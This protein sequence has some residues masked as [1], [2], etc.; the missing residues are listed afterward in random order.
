MRGLIKR[1]PPLLL[2]A[3]LMG[4]TWIAAY[5]LPTWT[6]NLPGNAAIGLVLS[7][8]GTLILLLSVWEF[9]QAQTTVNP[10]RPDEAS[11]VV[12]QGVYRFTRNPMYLSFALWLL[13]FSYWL[14]HPLGL[15]LA[16]L[17]VIYIDRFQI[18]FEEAAMIN[19]FGAEYKNYMAQV[20]RWV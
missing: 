9:R 4:L 13:G 19:K 14:A 8:A 1:P 11:R 2:V 3:S 10:T 12:A 17:F 20:R 16:C 5:Y 7:G 15:L 6:A 18:P